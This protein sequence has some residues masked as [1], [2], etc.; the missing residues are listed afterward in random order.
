MSLFTFIFFCRYCR[1]F[2]LF[3]PSHG[4]RSSRGYK[5]SYFMCF[6]EIVRP[7]MDTPVLFTPCRHYFWMPGTI[8]V[9]VSRGKGWEIG[10]RSGNVKVLKKSTSLN[11][12]KNG[13]GMGNHT[14]LEYTTCIYI[15]FHTANLALNSTFC[16]VIIILINKVVVAK[17]GKQNNGI[18][19]WASQWFNWLL[20]WM[21][22]WMKWGSELMSGWMDVWVNDPMNEII[23]ERRNTWRG[24]RLN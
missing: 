23:N 15:F 17:K 9:F 8:W 20:N 22:E 14:C 7:N 3:T 16:A 24:G 6:S 21:D 5:S 11:H 19:E 4:R 2:F 12:Y 10:S 13:A 1:Y 18:D